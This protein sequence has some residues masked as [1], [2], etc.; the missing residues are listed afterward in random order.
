MWYVGAIIISMC[1][2]KFIKEK[3]TLQAVV[4]I[5][6][7]VYFSGLLLGSYSGIIRGTAVEPF[8]QKY[9]FDI[10]HDTNNVFFFGFP[11]F[12]FG[13]YIRLYGMP[14]LLRKKNSCIAAAVISYVLLF[15]ELTLI[16]KLLPEP[17]DGSYKFFIFLPF[18]E[19]S[20]LCLLLQTE[21]RLSFDAKILRKLSTGIYFS[22]VAVY[23]S[24]YI[25][26]GVLYHFGIISENL[27]NTTVFFATAVLTTAIAVAVYKIDNKY[28]NKLF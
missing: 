28:L 3:R 6:A 20:L 25:I 11:F 24:I 2:L 22:H 13:Y 5:S 18:F 17:I 23:S 26:S 12:S 9:Y 19:I 1:I 8:L 7:A 15:T 16:T 27:N 14:K 21:I 10:F 4:G